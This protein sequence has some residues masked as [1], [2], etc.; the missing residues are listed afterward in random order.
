MIFYFFI[1]FIKGLPGLQGEPGDKG[2]PGQQ[3]T[4]RTQTQI[5]LYAGPE[6][7]S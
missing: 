4:G 7:R 3:V 6:G 1:S 5:L 2:E